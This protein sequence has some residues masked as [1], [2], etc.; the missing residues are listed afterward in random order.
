MLS[1]RINI[2]IYIVTT[3]PD[4][5]WT[6]CVC[7]VWTP[8]CT[9]DPNHTG[10]W[11]EMWSRLICVTGTQKYWCLWCY[12]SSR[13]RHVLRT[14]HHHVN[15]A[16]AARYLVVDVQLVVLPGLQRLIHSCI[17]LHRGVGQNG[18]SAGEQ[19]KHVNAQ[20]HRIT[21]AQF[22]SARQ[23]LTFTFWW[24]GRIHTSCERVRILNKNSFS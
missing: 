20:Q 19:D 1:S 24:R 18:A 13:C 23:T 7:P 6:N 2:N 3:P 5:M 22:C 8:V 21:R 17:T 16:F 12:H 4:N 14:R 10:S 11:F 9:S 15:K